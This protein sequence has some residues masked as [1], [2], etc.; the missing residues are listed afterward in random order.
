MAG[1]DIRRAV[2]GY[3]ADGRSRISVAGVF[4]RSPSKVGRRIRGHYCY[5][6]VR[7]KPL[8]KKMRIQLGVIT[9][10]GEEAQGVAD[11]LVDAG[12]RGLMN[13]APVGL[14]VSPGVCVENIDMMVALA[15]LSYF[16]R[17]GDRAS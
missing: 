6:L 12:V 9:V 1:L 15:K 2:V 3:V 7:L 14:S 4:D 16:V 13:F 17:S 5:P 11:L 8:V 10:P